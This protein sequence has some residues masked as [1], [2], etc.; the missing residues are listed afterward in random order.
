MNAPP[1]LST[2]PATPESG[3]EAT[4]QVPLAREVGAIV[5]ASDP[6][7]LR[8]FLDHL[9]AGAVLPGRLV[10]VTQED[11]DL[12][13]ALAGH[14]ARRRFDAVRII[15]VKGELSPQRVAAAAL[16]RLDADGGSTDIEYAWLLTQDCRPAHRALAALRR[17]ARTSRT[18]AVVAP[19]L[20]TATRPAEL[21]SV[22]YVLTRAGRWVPQPRA[23]EGDQG[24]YDDRSDVL[25]TATL[26]ALLRVD[27]LRRLGGWA[28]HLDSAAT[29]VAGDVDLGWRLHRAGRR[30][31]LA[32]RAV[33]EVE[34]P[35][36]REQAT[37]KPRRASPAPRPG[38]LT[39]T[40]RR[41]LRSI[42]LGA[43]PL[44]LW[45]LRILG[46]LG[47]ALLAALVMLLAKRPRQAGREV[48]DA[49]AVLRL[50]RAWSAHRRFA[51]IAQ[52]P[53]RT[54]RQLFVPREVART[55]TLDDL[56]PQRRGRGILSQQDLALR[57]PRPQAVA[58][59]AF[60]AV[61]VTVALTLSAGRELGG[62]L[63][64]RVG[65]G[66]SG[67]EAVGS[68]ASAAGIWRSA[69][70][71][72]AGPGLGAETAF[73][74]ALALL[75]G[76]TWV[77]EHLPVLDVPAAPASATVAAIL[78]LTLP[79]AALSMYAGLAVIS[80]RRSIRAFGGVAWAATGLAADT[81]AGGRL[82]GAVVLV[83][84]PLAAAALARALSRRG[85]SYDAAQAGL[86]LAVIGA[87]APAV[88]ILAMA[89]AVLLGLRPRWSLRRALGAA[90]VPVVV[91]APSVRNLLAEPQLALGGVGL[92]DWA[93]ATPDPWRLALLDVSPPNAEALPA[94]LAAAAPYAAAPLLALALV[95]LLR[96]RRRITTLAGTAVA[97]LALAAAVVSRLVVLDTVPIGVSGAGEP[98]RPW[99]GTLLTVYAL[100]VVALAVRG[101]DVLARAALSHRSLRPAAPVAGLLAVGA[102]VLASGW[103]GFGSTLSTVREDRPEVAVD[104]ADG[105]L[106]GRSIL[107]G[108]L[109][110]DEGAEGATA[111]RILAAEGGLP[112]RT[113]PALPEVSGSLDAFV[114]RLD[115]AALDVP[116]D[117]LPGG[118]AAVLARHAVGFVAL[119]G[120]MPAEAVRALDATDGLRRLP[121]REGVSWWRV[122]AT[123]SDVPSPARL[124]LRGADGDGLVLPSRHH[125]QTTVEVE[126]AGTLEVAQTAPWS[127]VADVTL[128]GEPLTADAS[129][130]TVTY[131]VP[132]AGRLDIDIRTPD[133]WL[134]ALAGV[135]LL[136]IA[137]LALPFGG[138]GARPEEDER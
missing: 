60:L 91:L 2:G 123:T 31:L 88:T 127:R 34:P 102:L 15:R 52:V 75:A 33:V 23:G 124:V 6:A 76:A 36:E 32:S 49:L 120:D 51:R 13:P 28:P 95:G 113:L 85:R 45:P 112:V 133:S 130:D 131:V 61:L 136:V 132:A 117:D 90:L 43:Q 24:Q 126:G 105:A 11:I 17:A 89:V 122:D 62:S 30:V 68:R 20:R 99:A 129:G 118:A 8:A 97:A 12:G 59:P 42:A 73:S 63:V 119:T 14:H 80:P 115:V 53:R 40:S 128:D 103:T 29:Q 57:G 104:H 16:E 114:S 4:T 79:A 81:V 87:F 44:A 69:V 35:A 64:G 134:L 7:R 66:V 93:G 74:P 26:G 94:L 46:V 41:A 111:Y 5:A 100:V 19:K 86:A 107:V 108:R 50:G 48:V 1:P 78:V 96:G 121:D 9:A 106:A 110:A 39:A 54:L 27:D 65:W 77:S 3:S 55:A 84:A 67:G 116:G 138:V 38:E 82:G 47:T 37:A 83:L 10:V 92:F 72:W 125:A 137:Y 56:I 21:L 70:D 109:G 101:L 18:A 25:A 58:H 71:A 22:G 98:V 135:G